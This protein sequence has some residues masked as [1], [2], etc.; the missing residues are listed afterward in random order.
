M[1]DLNNGSAKMNDFNG[2]GDDWLGFSRDDDGQLAYT[3]LYGALE[4]YWNTSVENLPIDLQRRIKHKFP[5]CTSLTGMELVIKRD[6]M[7]IDP[8][9]ELETYQSLKQY[10]DHELEE[11]IKNFR[12]A[13]ECNISEALIYD[14]QE[15]LKKILN[16]VGHH[17]PNREPMLWKAIYLFDKKTLPEL[18]NLKRKANISDAVLA[19]RDEAISIYKILNLQRFRNEKYVLAELITSG[20]ITSP[21]NDSHYVKITV[22]QQQKAAILDWVEKNGYDPIQLPHYKT[23]K[24]CEVKSKCKAEL[25]LR[26]KMFLSEPVFDKVWQFLR[27]EKKINHKRH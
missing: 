17:W 20:E 6:D 16:D 7:H 19:L 15:P 18:I 8:T 13:G 14:L 9:Q 25:L 5:T 26:R 2:W 4:G 22:K 10:V 12:K 23:G 21:P 3:P 24:R 27:N 11:K 1:S